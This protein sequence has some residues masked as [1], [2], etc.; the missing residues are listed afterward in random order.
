MEIYKKTAPISNGQAIAKATI[1]LTDGSANY[2]LMVAYQ[3]ARKAAQDAGF[4]VNSDWNT[5]AV[6]GKLISAKT[7]QIK[8][9]LKG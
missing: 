7:Q 1:N 2:A 3:E 8:D 6:L 5:D 9:A 4:V